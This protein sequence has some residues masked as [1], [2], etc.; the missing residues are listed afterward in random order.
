MKR[1]ARV[2]FAILLMS[3]AASALSACV[4]VPER[5]VDHYRGP[6]HYWHDR[7]YWR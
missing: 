3:F 7:G 5:E 2:V 4:V 6:P 1:N